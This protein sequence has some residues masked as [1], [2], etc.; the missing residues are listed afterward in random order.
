MIILAKEKVV[1][2]V[3]VEVLGMATQNSPVE[4]LMVNS[5]PQHP[6]AFEDLAN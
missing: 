4:F 6:R 1:P 2:R 5:P 3:S